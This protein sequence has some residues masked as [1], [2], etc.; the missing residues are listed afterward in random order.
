VTTA[1]HKVRQLFLVTL[2]LLLL[3]ACSEPLS[4]RGTDV[5]GILPDLEFELTGSDGETVSADAF[6]G[7]TTLLYFGFTSCPDVC[8]TTLSQI[9]VALQEM[10]PAA[11]DIQVLLVSV[12][13]DR[14][15]PR[16][17]KEYTAAFG[18]W[19]HGLTGT[20]KKLRALNHAFKVD[21]LAQE[22]DLQGRYD[23]MHSNRVFAFDS[24]GRCRLLLPNTANTEA[25]VAD[26]TQLL[27]LS[28]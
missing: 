6:R 5:T 15:T 21:F 4:W 2:P 7:R 17:M 11:A 20:K 10:G 1:L 13:P 8:P 16:A 19:L 3:A 22:P 12:D 28:R 25:L 9:S 23:V 14:D 26:L 24:S 27:E 18:P